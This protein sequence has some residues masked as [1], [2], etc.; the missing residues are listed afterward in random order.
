MRSLPYAVT[1]LLVTMVPGVAMARKARSGWQKLD[2]NLQYRAT[3]ASG[4]P[5]SCH[6][7]IRNA[8][9]RSVE[10]FEFE[11]SYESNRNSQHLQQ[12]RNWK[13][14]LRP[15][16]EISAPDWHAQTDDCGRIVVRLNVVRF[17]R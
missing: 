10:F 17:A 3:M 5:T 14:S 2:G 15:N 7:F 9:K 12:R 16:A 6:V 13:G 4:R 1:L 8:A 11:F